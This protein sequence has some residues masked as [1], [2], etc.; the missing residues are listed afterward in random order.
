MTRATLQRPAFQAGARFPL[1]RTLA[2]LM[3]ASASVYAQGGRASINGTVTDPTGAVVAGAHVSAKNLETG[4][5]STVTTGSEGFYSLPFLPLGRYE[6][7]VSH[8]GFTTE[9]QTG[10][11]LSAEQAA[12]VNFTLKTGQLTTSVEVNAEA[13]ELETTS[14]AISQVVDQKS[15]VE[16]PLDGRNPAELVYVAPGAV[17]GQT[18]ANSIG[19]PGSGSGFPNSGQETAASVNGSRMGGVFY[20]LDGV[21]HMDNY[22]QNANPFPNPDA[23]QEFR[24]ITNNFDAQYGYTSGAVVSIATRSGTNQWHGVGFEF[25]RNSDLNASDFFTHVANPLKRNQ[26]GGSIGGPI[27]HDKLFIFGNFQQTVEHLAIA[28]SSNFVPNNNM[29]NGDFSQIP[30]QL[31]DPQ[32]VPY[33][34]N[35]IPVSTFSPISLKLEQGLPKTDDPAGNVLLTGRLQIND[36]RE[37]TVRSDYY[38]SA[39]QHIS[40]R[41][42]WDNF[43]R[44][45]FSGDGDYLNSDRSALAQANNGAIDYTWSIRPNLVNDFRFGYNR[46]NSATTPGLVQPGGG[47]LS[48]AALGANIPQPDQTIS[49]LDLNNGFSISQTPVVQQRH[50]WII[51]DTISFNKGRHSILAGINVLTQYSLEDAGWGADPQMNFS[52]A[53]TGSSFADFLLGD[54]N[55]FSQSGGE[56]NQLHDIQFAGFV[57]DSIKLKPNLTV[58]LGVRWEPQDAPKYSGNKLPFFSPGQQS[59][60]FPNAPEDLVYA[61]DAGVPVGGWSTDWSAVLPRVS[62]AWQ[63]A[64]LPNTSIRASF[65]IMSLPYDYST[66][67]HMGT[68]APFSPQFSINYNQVGSCVLNIANPYACYAPTGFKPPFPPFS[69]P[70]FTPAQDV[71][72]VIPVSIGA[73][74]TPGFK[75]PR[76]QTWNLSIERSWSDYL[77]RVAYVGYEIY[78]L[79]VQEQLSPGLFATGGQTTLLPDFSNVQGYVSWNTQSYNALQISAEKHFSRGFQFISNFTWS[80]NLDS[81][82]VATAANTGPVFDPYNLRDN[83]GISDL[84]VPKI[85]N[86][87]FIYQEPDLKNLG[88]IGSFLLG[89]WEI[90]GI[91]V[92]NSGLPFSIM[93]GNGNNNSDSNIGSDRADIVPGAPLNVH[94]GSLNNWL[95]EYFNTAAFVSNAPGTFGDSARNYLRGQNANNV[96]LQFSKNFA[97]RERYR[98]QFRWEMFNALNRTWFYTPDNTVGDAAFGRITSDNNSPRYME[99]ALKLYF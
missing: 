84:S 54:M 68:T 42:F 30:V 8:P 87:T 43:D 69:G 63:P 4:Q 91:W 52:G 99:A 14:G 21:P 40:V 96:D 9:T 15:I 7:T 35:Q 65:G 83:R 89:G 90:A 93:G 77:F 61:G 29:L 38:F 34:N 27:K 13:V 76:D 67:N 5:L 16:L 53:V 31:H 88:H 78:H 10:F 47:A 70:N 64:A 60:R 48:P 22:F 20:M 50:N 3:L 73:T 55:N 79:P 33:P 2:L 75:M 23:T 17:N 92:V 57:Q 74:F 51:D 72:F 46:L 32:G 66:Y 18:S 58:N 59:T 94:Q 37:F 19:L 36:S 95:N 41:Y 12:T 71:S 11:T 81:S 98:L 85:F 28:S 82:S 25:L 6:V 62:I 39:T 1:L 97:F 80:K 86:N 49:Q 24:V 56:Y 45:A 26:F 44:P